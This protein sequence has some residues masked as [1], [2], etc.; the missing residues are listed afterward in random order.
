M[1]IFRDTIKEVS[2]SEIERLEKHSFFNSYYYH[3]PI[4]GL[5]GIILGI[6]DIFNVISGDIGNPELLS[7]GL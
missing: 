6:M 5:M 1:N 2:I 7:K 4:L 3:L